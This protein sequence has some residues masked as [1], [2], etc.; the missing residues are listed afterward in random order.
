MIWC[1]FLTSAT[2]RPTMRTLHTCTCSPRLLCKTMRTPPVPTCGAAHT[3]GVAPA[4]ATHTCT[5]CLATA[6]GHY[7]QDD[8]KALAMV[9]ALQRL[10]LVAKFYVVAN[11]SNAVDRGCLAKGTLQAIN[12][13]DEP[14]PLTLTLAL[15]PT[16]NP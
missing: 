4:K 16:P 1:L 15:N 12:A 7:A 11:T 3:C 6:A 9:V 13:T 8:E 10:G 2:R 14:E 5:P